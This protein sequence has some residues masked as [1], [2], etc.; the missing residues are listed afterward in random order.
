MAASLK[1]SQLSLRL[2]NDLKDKME[3]YARLTGRTKSHVAMEA[4]GSYL[5]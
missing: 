5:E 4:L 3:V 1:D 2:P